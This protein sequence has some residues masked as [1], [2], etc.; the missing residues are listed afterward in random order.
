MSKSL[1]TLLDHLGG[2]YKFHG[3]SH[4]GLHSGNSKC[5]NEYFIIYTTSQKF[6]NDKIFYV[7]ERNL[8]CSPSLHLFD[9]V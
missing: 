5:F 6:L 1:E 4:D 3:E 9:P 8:F 2:L 7:F